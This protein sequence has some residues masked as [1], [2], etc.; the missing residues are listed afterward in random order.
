[1]PRP[2]CAV[3]TGF[4]LNQWAYSVQTSF[5]RNLPFFFLKQV[6]VPIE[7]RVPTLRTSDI[8]T[9]DQTGAIGGA[10]MDH[11]F[12][13]EYTQTWSGG[14]QTEIMPST[15]FEVFYL[16]SYTIGADNSTI[17][18]VPEPGPGA[19]SPRRDV[20][21]LAGIRAIR[22][23]GKSIYHAVTF[24]GV[25]RL[26]NNISFNVAYTLSKSKDDASSPGATAFESNVPQDVRNLFQG[27]NALSS[28]DHRHQF[29]GSGTFEL[30]FY[31]GVGG[32]REALLGNWRFNGIFTMQSGAPFTVNITED[33]ANVG[34][35][36]AQ[37]PNLTGDP[38]SPGWPAHARPVDQHRR[39]LATGSV[40]LRQRRQEPGVRA[41][42]CESGHVAPEELDV[43]KRFAP[44]VPLGDLQRV[45]PRQLR[46]AEPVL[47]LTQLRTH[48]QR[49]E[50][51][52]DAVRPA[53]Q[54][55]VARDSSERALG[56]LTSS[57][58]KAHA[59]TLG[60][61]LC[62]VAPAAALPE[63]GFL[64]TWL[65]RGYAGEM[66]YLERTADRRA[67]V[68]RVLPTARTVV[69]L[70][71]V[72]NVDRPYSTESA[73]PGQAHVSRYA[74]GTDYHDTVG[75]RTEA[76]LAWMREA[77][78]I[79]FEAKAY[80][81]TGPVQER[82]YA[83]HAGLGWIGK[84][85]CVINPDLGSWLFLSEILCSLPFDTDPPA[86]DQCGTCTLCLEA[87]PTGAIVDPWVL[88]STRCVSY[89]PHDRA[90]GRDPR[91]TPRSSRHPRVRLRHL[92]G[93]VPVE[94]AGR[95]VG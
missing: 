52:R 16:G 14:I 72:Y 59:R 45:Q 70:A 55:L 67:D 32:W 4:F 75:Q 81:D 92:S 71:T 49:A 57:D 65:D 6:D 73:D 64:R 35:G 50:R 3:A 63:L 85:T 13:V 76:L 80:V 69:A 66:G 90:E 22:F 9:V 88:D 2:L 53:I 31:V 58:I 82:V 39:V 78:D 33:R 43:R 24:K 37:R 41:R 12:R 23:D 36:P 34:A 91:A 56:A 44:G 94:R 40:H 8:L 11:D 5:T 77:S 42:V 54:L 61:Q 15:V 84:N 47:R 20:P 17:R 18:N 87:C 21:E 25:R 1:M 89:V 7:Q 74:W 27:E 79:P 95:A 60:F 62:G 51:A 83:Q 30:P 26:S 68:R 93:R 10:I 29:V 48:F 28:F 19:L 86:L 38:K 46:R